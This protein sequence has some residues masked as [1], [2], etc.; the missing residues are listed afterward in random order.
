MKKILEIKGLTK[1]FGG[2]KAVNNVDM[3][4]EEKEIKGLIG[5][6]GAGKTT[7]FNML[8]CSFAPTSGEIIFSGRNITGMKPHEVCRMGLART[9]QV[10]RPF[11]D[12]DILGNIMVG[13]FLKI[14]DKKEARKKAEKIY[15][16]MRFSEKP[17]Q[18]AHN[19]TTV[20]RKKLEVARAMAT[21]PK[22][23]LLDE[24]MAGCNPQEKKEI[25]FML[26][27]L[28]D[29]GLTMII[30]EHDVKAIMSI[31]DNIVILNRGEKLCEGNAEEVAN[32]PKAITAYL[33]EDY[34][35]AKN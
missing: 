5:P 25:L 7:C 22:L 20:D 9:F 15:E 10:V 6:N 31:C 17:G 24:V 27:T 3:A 29:E 32:D 34:T 16:L 11:G 4:V 33:G 1:S 8:A 18:I 14:R 19:L 35:H 2:L 13:V 30:I 28:R 26:N 23:L 12:M 21:E